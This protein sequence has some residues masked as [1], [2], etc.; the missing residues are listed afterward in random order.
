MTLHWLH[1]ELGR[2]TADGTYRVVR[3]NGGWQVLDAEWA[4]LANPCPTIK[5]AQQVAERLAAKR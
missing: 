1:T 2:R 5:E 4:P 3:Q